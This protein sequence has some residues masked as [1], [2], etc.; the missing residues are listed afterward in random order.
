MNRW[1]KFDHETNRIKFYKDEDIG[2]EDLLE[3]A[4][5]LTLSR[6]GRVFAVKPDNVPSGGE[7]AAVL[8]Y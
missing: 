6:G 3:Y 5:I 8:R 7:V 2:D 4:S 1:G